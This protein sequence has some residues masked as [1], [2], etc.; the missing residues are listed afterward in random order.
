MD[1]WFINGDTELC[2]LNCNTKWNVL[3]N[4]RSTA[5]L[6]QRSPITPKIFSWPVHIKIIFCLEILTS[7][8]LLSCLSSDTVLV[9]LFFFNLYH[10]MKILSKSIVVS[11]LL[12]HL[13]FSSQ[14]SSGLICCQPLAQF[15]PPGNTTPPMSG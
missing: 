2:K 13:S 14:I 12:N 3:G 10:T 4:G 11:V 7:H 9:C 5:F 1:N 15:L 6:K 8:S